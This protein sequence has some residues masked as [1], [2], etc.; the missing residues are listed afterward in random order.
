MINR[1]A[2]LAVSV[3][4][5]GNSSP[6]TQS[7]EERLLIRN[8][9][10]SGEYIAFSYAG[11]LWRVERA[12]GTALRLTEGPA[13]D[14]YP[15]FAPDGASIA[16]SRRGADDWDVYV[17]GVSG[18]ETRQVTYHPEMDIVR[19]WSPDG[20]DILFMSHRDEEAVFRLYTIAVDGVFPEALPLPRAWEGSYAPAG[21]RI[22]YVPISMPL[23][24][25]GGE[26]RY[27]RGGMT[28]R[29]WLA[30]IETSRIEELPREN[31]NDRHPMW[32]DGTIYFVS[33]RSGTFNLHSYVPTSRRVTQLTDY[34]TYGVES[35]SAG[36]GAIAFVQD[37]GIKIFDRQ[38]GAVQT[39]N[40]QVDPDRSEMEPRT[41][42]G[43]RFIQSASTTAS[44]DKVV[45]GARGEIVSFDLES[46]AAE[47]LSQTP[48]AAERY[49]AVSPDGRWVAY[50]SDESGQYEL[51]IRPASGEGP[52]RQLP[53][54]LRPS[55]YRELT[56]SPDSKHLA[57]ID[58]RLTLWVADVETGGANRVGTSEYSDQDRYYPAW[59]PDGRWLAFS[60]YESNR[61]RTVYIYDTDR[62]R[63]RRV[64]AGR[65]HAEYPVFD[66]SGRYL[67]FVASNTAP[68]ADFGWSVL[69]GEMSKPLV[70]RR[71]QV[72]LLRPDIA[73]PIIPLT[74]EPNPEVDSAVI[75]PGQQPAG[76]GPPG[77]GRQ[78]RPPSG[79]PP[80]MQGQAV[81]QTVVST[82]G[83]VRR[84]VPL[85]LPPRDIAGLA[86]GEPGVLY[87]LVRD[88]SQAGQPGR[89]ARQ[90]LYRYE[91]SKP[92]ELTQLIEDVSEF[93][94]TEDGR[95]ILYR[96]GR[97]WA[98]VSGA[99]PPAPEEGRLDLQAIQI[100]VDPAAEWQQ[101]YHEAWGLM[102]DYFYDPDHHGQ[103]L[104]ELERHYQTY[105]PAVTRR[106]DLNVLLGKALGHISVSH[107]GVRGGDIPRP[108]GDR[109]RIGLLGGDYEIA[110]GRYRIVRIYPSGH[111]NSGNPLHRSPFDEPGFYVSPGDYLLAVDD[112]EITAD[113]NLYSYFAGTA[114]KPVKLTVG[115]DANGR[116][117]RTFTI[118]P[119][120][121]ENTLRRM[122]W[123]ERNRLVVEEESQGVLGYIWVPNFGS[124]S[125]E[126]I[127]RQLLESTDKRGLVIDQRFGGGG[128]TA[129]Y[130]IELL[131]RTALYYY[132]FR[133]GDD[134]SVPAN[135]MPEA[136]VLLIN[137]VNGSAAETFAL[138]FKLG[139]LGSTIGT[140]TGGSGIGPY[141]FIPTLIDG[142]RIS[143]PNRA[144]YDP[145][146]EWGIE[147]QGIEPDIEVAWYPVDWR[148]G[149]D[150]QLQMAIN[151]ALQTIVDRPPLEV[152]KPEYP[153]HQ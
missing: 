104:S 146:G 30:D 145:S 77:A 47:N 152:V 24:L 102:R 90:S 23:D 5:A 7:Q 100:D 137:D 94:V 111:F 91:L 25:F 31:V 106:S 92:R 70:S 36:G 67:Y 9:S 15:V 131:R 150:S 126:L 34:Q 21:D 69:S 16:F 29:I 119:T 98:M 84:I 83:L 135:A 64:T 10:V 2:I 40:V 86:A 72:V 124:G 19:G 35:A 54:E 79:G 26:W 52:V 55:Y 97:D 127:L 144:A 114:L 59:S 39:V 27:Y 51:R 103:N 68:L 143:I 129:D 66:K 1:L 130:L 134:L 32:V 80:G 107:L 105:L 28:S 11:D 38:S 87:V 50:L 132:T 41:V 20:G 148:Q 118:V 121:G 128:I 85:P 8:V 110:E 116:G 6:V 123:A 12:G 138:M 62:A 14:D 108:P 4:L 49:P 43:A 58:K 101:I 115:P 60:E 133:Q 74:G 81:P 56:W 140:R 13:E 37:G 141:V 117:S 75:I 73:S 45:F 125:I 113:R 96:Q 46:G 88:W 44:G 136:K 65:V 139:N 33:D 142:G 53:V 22:A 78:G 93:M 82:Q 153:V 63:K 112:E 48:G 122:N 109:S 3:L 42:A 71:L 17:I 149:R 61:L 95:R 76:G 18:G 89:S 151:I 147:N 57:F 99:E 120:V